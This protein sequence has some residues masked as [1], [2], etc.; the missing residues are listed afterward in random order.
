[1]KYILLVFLF[2]ALVGCS[3][4]ADTSGASS[5]N[6]NA[7]ITDAGVSREVSSYSCPRRLVNDPYPGA[8]ALYEDKNNNQ[9]CDLSE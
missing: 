5:D 6:S 8:C 3:I 1:M 7:E 4:Q 9:L 2:I